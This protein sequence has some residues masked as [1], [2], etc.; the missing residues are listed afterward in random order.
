MSPPFPPSPP[1]GPPCGIYFSLRKAVQPAPPF[2]ERTW[3]FTE[4]TNFMKYTSESE[5]FFRN[6]L[7]E[8]LSVKE[9]DGVYIGPA[10][11]SISYGLKPQFDV[12]DKQIYENIKLIAKIF[13]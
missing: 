11:M 12:K 13:H 4:S 6:N 3:I 8:I 7:D 1:S 5:N 2:P 10:D 9:L